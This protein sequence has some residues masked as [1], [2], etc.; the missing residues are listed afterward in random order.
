MILLLSWLTFFFVTN[1]S[2][3]QNFTNRECKQVRK[4]LKVCVTLVPFG[5]AWFQ[6]CEYYMS[7]KAS[8]NQL[9]EGW[10]KPPA[11]TSFRKFVD[12]LTC[13]GTWTM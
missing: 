11:K 2:F 8:E 9:S 3:Q 7:K 5:E 6:R 4:R 1:D 13:H 12:C 10:E